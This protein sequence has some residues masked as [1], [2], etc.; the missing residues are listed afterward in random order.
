[1]A[2][3]TTAPGEYRLYSDLA[4]WW[5]LISPPQEYAVD[6]AAVITMFSSAE[7]AVHEVLDLG[8]GGG[9][10]AVHLKEHLNLTLVDLSEEMLA[11]SRRMNPE[12]QHIQGDMLTLRLD[13]EFDA[14]LVH[15]AI[16]YVIR[17]TDLRR[18]MA[19]A[20]AHCR[21]GGIAVFVP[22]YTAETFRPGSGHG[23]SSN[24]AGRQGT[25][26]QWLTDPDPA[27]D[28]I[29]AEYEFKL[30]AADGTV[31]VVREAHKLGAFSRG[32][33]LRSLADT[34]F[35]PAAHSGADVPAVPVASTATPQN[36][37]IGHRP[38]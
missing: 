1:M 34:G 8:S 14:V 24:E 16:D 2:G 13:R 35:M 27:D 19:T 7:I 32:T 21:P 18:V 28:W 30:R 38:R 9:H 36:L 4:D 12:C 10:N 26:R 5:P 15:D 6:A 20:F 33:W 25:F 17:E 22:D 29:L 11:V 31:Q 37:F 23:G 3:M